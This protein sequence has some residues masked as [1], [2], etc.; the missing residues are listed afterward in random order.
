MIKIKDIIIYPVKGLAGISLNECLALEKGLEHDR[1]FMLVEPDGK[2]ISQREYP[3]LALFKTKI[4]GEHL[5]I[6]YGNS[7]LRIPLL[8]EETKLQVVTV[9]EHNV[10]AYRSDPSIDEWFS[11]HLGKS[12]LLV[13]MNEQNSRVKLLKKSPDTTQVSFADGYPYL[14]LGTE[15]MELLNQKMGLDYKIDRF[16]ANIILETVESHIEDT[17]DHVS[18][19][20]TAFRM[21]KPCARCQVTTIDQNTGKRGKEPLKTLA[22]YRK[23]D[24]KIYFGM[25]AVCLTEGKI[26]VGDVLETI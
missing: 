18:F 13:Y 1:R 26:R 10:E 7:E 9:W 11:D 14:F 6:S 19:S 4:L 8:K 17:L 16:R 2:F 3:K 12:C 21:I 20:G 5:E 25:N 22:T 24:H 15:S 23:K